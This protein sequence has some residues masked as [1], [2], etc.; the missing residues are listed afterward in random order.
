MAV[1]SPPRGS[2]RSRRNLAATLVL[3]AV[4]QADPGDH[5][6]GHASMHISEGALIF[7]AIKLIPTAAAFRLPIR[8]PAASAAG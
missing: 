5:F 3:L 2:R 6:G 4:R 1:P 7:G 8:N